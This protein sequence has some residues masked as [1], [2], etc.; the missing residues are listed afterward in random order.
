MCTRMRECR[1]AE[2]QRE[3]EKKKRNVRKNKEGV[4]LYHD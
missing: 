2:R 1:N 4:R 3:E